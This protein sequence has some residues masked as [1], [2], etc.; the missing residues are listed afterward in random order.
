[1]EAASGEGT[2]K[3]NQVAARFLGELTS[4]NRSVC[5]RSSIRFRA[6]RNRESQILLGRFLLL[7]KKEPSGEIKLE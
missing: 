4:A 5:I 3:E 6:N 2:V 7:G 1:M